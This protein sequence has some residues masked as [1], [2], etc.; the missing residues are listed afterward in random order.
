MDSQ[1]NRFTPANLSPKPTEPRPGA[2][3]YDLTWAELGGCLPDFTTAEGAHAWVAYEKQGLNK[4]ANSCILTVGYAARDGSPRE[5]TVFCKR[6]EDPASAEAAKYAH[7]SSHD[8]PTPRLLGVAAR[9]RGEVIVLEFLSTVGIE[10]YDGDEFLLLIARLNAVQAPPDL[11]T[12]PPGMPEELFRARVKAALTTLAGDPGVPVT[13]DPDRWF[14]AYRRAAE[15]VATLPVA[16]NHG[17]LYFQ[18]VGWSVVDGRPRLVVFDLETMGLR[19]RFHD[20]ATV[21]A[22]TATYTCRAQ[23]ALFASYLDA[24]ASLTGVRID[25]TQ[26]WNEMRLVRT[27]IAYQGLPWRIEML[28]HPDL[29][30][31]LADI[32]LALHDDLTALGLLD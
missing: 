11:F 10:P 1:A 18:Q 31:T 7:L 12:L 23:R 22:G 6:S 26:A 28:G 19:P 13:V 15:S 17:E 20:I 29:T 30:E 8:I 14:A 2:L 5:Q 16:P 21:L 24:L 32:A 27:V 3:P 9:E 4:G 25:E